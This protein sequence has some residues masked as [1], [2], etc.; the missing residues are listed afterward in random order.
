MTNSDGTP[1]SGATVTLS[2]SV[3]R[4]GITDAA[5]STVISVNAI[6]AGIIY[7]TTNKTGYKNAITT[8]NA[9]GS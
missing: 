9:V 4:A 1:L 5:G 2:G 6:A 7:A 8:L 3:T